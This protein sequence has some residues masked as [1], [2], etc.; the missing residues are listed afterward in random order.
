M[1]KENTNSSFRSCYVIGVFAGTT[2][3]NT[4]KAKAMSDIALANVEALASGEDRYEFWCCGNTS[5]C[6]K[7]DNVDIYGR[8]STSPCQ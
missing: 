8:L 5:I 3:Y 4:Q 7:G 2:V 1:K 6:A